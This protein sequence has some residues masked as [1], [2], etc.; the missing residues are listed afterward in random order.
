[1]SLSWLLPPANRRQGWG[2]LLGGAEVVV[3]L[4]RAEVVSSATMGGGRSSWC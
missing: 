2:S 1:M 4:G 3:H